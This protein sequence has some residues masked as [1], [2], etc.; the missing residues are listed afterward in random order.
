[1]FCGACGRKIVDETRFCQYCGMP[2]MDALEKDIPRSIEKDI[3][4]R[5]EKCGSELLEDSLFCDQC[6]ARVEKKK[7]YN[8]CKVCRRKIE[9]DSSFCYICGSKQ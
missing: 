6:G 4:L 8:I 7:T 9:S 2:K 1:M 5:C 3:F